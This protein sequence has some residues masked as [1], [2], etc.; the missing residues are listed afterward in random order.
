MVIIMARVAGG[1]NIRQPNGLWPCG[2]VAEWP[3][4]SKQSVSIWSGILILDCQFDLIAFKIVLQ[5]V[6][7]GTR[8][9]GG[10]TT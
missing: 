6:H 4:L 2:L 5:M 3:Q 10:H 7:A 8:G 9:G 1:Y